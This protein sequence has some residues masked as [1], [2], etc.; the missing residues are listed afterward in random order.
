MSNT[1]NSNGTYKS[2]SSNEG[3]YVIAYY[4]LLMVILGTIFNATTFFVFCRAKFRN[5]AARPVIHYMRAIAIIDFVGLYGWTFESYISTIYNISLTYSYTVASCKF[6]W[7]FNFWTL[8]A[9]AW[10]HVFVSFDRYLFMSRIQPNTWF[11]RSKNILIIIASVITIFVLYN[12]H[13][14]LFVC[15]EN[16]NGY[17]VTDSRLYTFLP[18]FQ[19]LHL[20]IYDIIPSSL[21]LTFNFISIYH[22]YKIRHITTITNS[23]IRHRPITITLV[24]TSFLY[25][26][27]RTPSAVIYSYFYASL[28]T[29][30]WGRRLARGFNILLYTFPI[31]NFPIYLVTFSEFR[32]ELFRCITRRKRQIGITDA[33]NTQGNVMQIKLQNMS[34]VRHQL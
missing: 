9:S 8:Q 29:T 17:I 23:K 21:M 24:V 10:L 2:S 16:A 25:V 13:I 4:N 11:N 30:D 33:R 32:Q 15:Y 18:L 3:V 5:T 27:T 12:F 19:T 14:L 7:F 20:F 1:S 31:L 26:V 28:Q 34:N 22:L 6:A